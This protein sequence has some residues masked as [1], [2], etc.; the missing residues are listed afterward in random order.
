MRHLILRRTRTH[1]PETPTSGGRF[2]KTNA[3]GRSSGQHKTQVRKSG[4]ET[5]PAKPL[6]ARMTDTTASADGRRAAARGEVGGRR[7]RFGLC[8]HCPSAK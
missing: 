7:G 3:L 1:I 6:T 2:V 4:S 5:R 8:M